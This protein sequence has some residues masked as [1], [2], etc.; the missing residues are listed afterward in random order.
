MNPSPEEA[1]ITTEF[2]IPTGEWEQYLSTALMAPAATGARVVALHWLSRLLDARDRW[3]NAVDATPRDAEPESTA[4]EAVAALHRARVS[5]RRL[6]ATLREHRMTLDLHEG[7]RARRAIRQ[8][9]RAT[10][11]IRDRDVQREW[12]ETERDNLDVT[13]REQAD[14]LLQHLLLAAAND[15]VTVGR[16]FKKHLDPIAKPLAK[17]LSQYTTSTVIGKPV[18]PAPLSRLL[19]SR[20][21]RGAAH[22]RHDLGMIT[23]IESQDVLHRVRIRLKR[24]RAMLSPFAD[25]NPDVSAWYALAT[26]GQNLLGAMRDATILSQRARQQKYISLAETL[27]SVALAHY[28]AFVSTWC[29]DVPE[30]MNR[31]SAAVRALRS[32]TA[33]EA[34]ASQ[35]IASPLHQPAKRNGTQP[36]T[37]ADAVS[38]NHSIGLPL[39]IERKFLLHGLPPEAA[40]APSIRIEQGWLPGTAIRERLR[41]T[42]EPTG[43]ERC[44]RTIKLGQPGNRIEVE[45]NVDPVLFAQLWPF[46]AAAR[47]RKRRHM[48]ADGDVTWEIDV[49]LDRDLVLAEVELRDGN[50]AV[51]LPDW[52]AP[53][54]VREVTHDANYLNSVMAQQHVGTPHRELR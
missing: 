39:E 18:T 27:D 11:K 48:I 9:G 23:G 1:E 24:Q 12:L 6:R 2:P 17:R 8:L 28:E 15:R 49:F 4:T 43:E 30:I 5:L 29:R 36:V 7:K 22:F 50:Q 16:A 40:V 21:D 45:E 26:Q 31:M 33:L 54:V 53:F 51:T 3:Q 32:I 38:F 19:A 35:P 25:A 41:R 44:T 14:T 46:T 37:D 52:L 13:A 42:T 34:T 10:G 47:I 20:I